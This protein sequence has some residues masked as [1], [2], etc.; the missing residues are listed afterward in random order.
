MPAE[1]R[2]I[3]MTADAVGGVWTYALELARALEPV[4]VH[5][6]LATMGPPPTA[7]QRAAAYEIPNLE[8]IVRTFQLEWAD[9]PWDDVHRAGEWLLSLESRVRPE[10]VHLNGYVHAAL[11]FRAPVLVV[12]HSCLLSWDA[13]IP[14]A[15]DPRKLSAYAAR[16]TP[17][18]RAADLVVAPSQS[19]LDSLERHYGPLARRMVIPNGRR[20]ELFVRRTKEPL[21]FTAGRLWDRA[22]NV[23]AVLAVAPRLSWPTAVGGASR[24]DAADTTMAGPSGAVEWLGPLDQRTLVTWLAR[25]SIF[26]LPARYEPFGLLPLEA[27]LSGCALVLG[28]I[29][30][31]REVWGDAAIYVPPDDY[32]ALAHSLNDLINSPGRVASR[33]AAARERAG[34]YSIHALRRRYLE[35]YHAARMHRAEREL[36]ACAS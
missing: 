31:L 23:D 4:G 3:L 20:E 25:A 35:A 17:G 1:P 16:V 18:V 8:L 30:S 19:M 26:A 28:D 10:V 12:G 24:Q 32:E 7:A 2:R 9:D 29:A 5:V 15:I 33:A 13:A 34:A 27:A 11:P 6:T 22:K 21:V 14:H 36:V